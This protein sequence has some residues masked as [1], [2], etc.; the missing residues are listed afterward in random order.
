MAMQE[1]S[2]AS[3]PSAQVVGNAFVEQ[4]YQILHQS[5]ELV[6]RFY[7]ESSVLSRP[8]SNGVMTSVTTMPGIN[9]KIVSLN[10][11]DYI[12]EI[13]TADAQQSYGSGV[14]VLVTGYL[15]GRDNL[16][17]KFAQS[18]FLAPQEKGFFVLNDVF[19]YVDDEVSTEP[20]SD[21][22]NVIN[23]NVEVAP[24]ASEPEQP[25]H[26]QGHNG[27]SPDS[28]YEEDLTNEAEVC[29]PSDNDDGSVIEEEIVEP[30]IQLTQSETVTVTVTS[31]LSASQDDAPKR[32]YASILKAMNANPSPKPFK[33]P[34]TNIKVKRPS[35][36]QEAI[37]KPA[38]V[39]GPSASTSEAG[40]EKSDVLVEAEGHSIY[41]RNLPQNA[42]AA[43]L[44]E[45]F[46]K[47]GPIKQG[48]IQ[49]RSNKQGFCF[50]F[51][52]F[53]SAS[54]MNSAIE[55]SPLMI[56]SRKAVIE[57]KRTTTRVSAAAT[58]NNGRGRYPSS[59]GGF[60]SESFRGRGN[61]GGGRGYGRNDFRSQGEFSGKPRGGGAG[62]GA[63]G[64]QRVDQNGTGNTGRQGQDGQK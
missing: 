17:K 18:F 43:Q 55:A 64:Y 32:S 60:R 28:S 41:V 53:E 36:N 10:Y 57:E 16:R 26:V 22:V 48:G 38:P 15:T 29:D 30:P 9:E 24:Q 58:A 42:T 49:V 8:E 21:P 52:E 7:Q 61:F 62:R 51:V 1:A 3:T 12:A 63:E 39:S 19:R 34:A 5:P 47:Y 56:G 4:Y 13:K 6:Y 54:S 59:R 37:A 46:S 11:K 31:E 20:A 44:E 2:P 45:V 23:E 50:G 25:S 27:P 14:I 35:S 40:P 33:A